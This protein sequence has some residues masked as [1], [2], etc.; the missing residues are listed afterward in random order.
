[1]P[2]TKKTTTMS[3]GP[4]VSLERDPRV[5][6]YVVKHDSGF[7]PCFDSGI[8]TLA[9][10]KPSIRRTARKG[11]WVL[12]FA[13]RNK[14]EAHLL[15]AMRVAEVLDF[16]AYGND[17]RYSKR[18]DNIYRRTE[19]GSFRRVARHEHHKDI[20]DQERDLRGKNA[21]IADF[22]WHDVK[23]LDLIAT[24]GDDIARRL[25]HSGRG[26]KV[27]GLVDG[28]LEAVVTILRRKARRTSSASIRS[29]SR[30]FVEHAARGRC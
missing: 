30:R 14:G 22:W 20:G 9:C 5:Y 25:W 17:R 15:Y 6:R 23:G 12:G 8:C 18:Q 2:P 11:D 10:C 16:T 26:H 24:L 4:P 21:L 28:D 19:D 29:N 1:M 27:N 13:Q 7:A 3:D